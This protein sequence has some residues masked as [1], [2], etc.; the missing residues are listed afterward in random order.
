[1][2]TVEECAE[3]VIRDCGEPSEDLLRFD[4]AVGLVIRSAR[5]YLGQLSSSDQMQAGAILS[6]WSPQTTDG[7]VPDAGAE[8]VRIAYVERRLD[9]YGY[10]WESVPIVKLSSINQFYESGRLAISLY[11]NYS[12]YRVL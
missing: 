8:T 4:S 12:K 2:P 5:F 6:D 1:M 7:V 9:D 3:S 10:R 11:D